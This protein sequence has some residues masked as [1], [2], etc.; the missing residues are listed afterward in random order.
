MEDNEFGILGVFVYCVAKN[1][2]VEVIDMDS[3]MGQECMDQ[4]FP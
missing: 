2:V 3:G 1:E 4:L